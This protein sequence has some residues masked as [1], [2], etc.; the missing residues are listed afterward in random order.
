MTRLAL[1]LGRGTLL[2]A[3]WVVPAVANDTDDVP[4]ISD[5]SSAVAP[6]NVLAP[7]SIVEGPGITVGEGTV[8]HPIVGIE[9][10]FI[11][12]AFFEEA[13][14][15]GSG[16]LRLVGQIATSSLSPER[17]SPTE[18]MA[19]PS[20]G[21]HQFRAAL[22]LSYDFFLS[23]ND[24][25]QA[26]GG[27]GIGALFRGSVFPRQTW[28]FRYL[29][30][31]ERIIRA[32]NFESTERTNRNINRLQLGLQYAPQGRSVSGLL[33]FENV[34][35]VFE[36]SQQRFANRMQNSIGLT[37]SWRYR[38][39]TVFFLEGNQGLFTG[40]GSTSQK[41][42][43]LPL[44]L[45]V[46]AQT[47][48]TLRTSIVAR[49]GY[50]NGFYSSGPSFS[51]ILGGLQFGYRYAEK[52]RILGMYE[53]SRQ[54]SINANFFR[55]HTFRVGIEQQLDPVMLTVT[56]E[57]RLRNYQGVTTFVPGPDTRDDL[58]LAMNAGVRYNFRRSLGA[59]VE[60]RLSTVQTNYMTASGDDP[61]FVRHEIVAGVRAAL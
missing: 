60:Y 27:L 43:S 55:D 29:E 45:A 37:V 2:V 36:D 42:S 14:P 56:P 40:L 54:D 1:A 8:L 31:F 35:D 11:S 53:Y 16:I 51:G 4:G 24:N 15:V 41:V 9:T 21:T 38:P 33:Q 22:R 30:N 23:G 47:L 39:M 58:I 6:A 18:P 48:L 17:L 20:V 46:G 10:G 57:L 49:I 19:A 7:V 26:Q 52:G 28:S 59:V 25:L 12:N 13:N 32:T 3:F 44:S 61:G 34:I 50:T 5:T